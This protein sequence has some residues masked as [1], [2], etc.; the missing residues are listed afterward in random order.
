MEVGEATW[1]H[2]LHE[3]EDE[4][5]VLIVLCLEDVLQPDD[6][7]MARQPL[8]ATYTD[9]HLSPH[10]SPPT[11]HPKPRSKNCDQTQTSWCGKM[12][13]GGQLVSRRKNERTCKYM[14]SR[15]VRCASV[16]FWKASKIFF[17]ATTD[18]VFLSMALN[19]TA[20]APLPS[21]WVISYLRRTCCHRDVGVM[22]SPF[23]VY[24]TSCTLCRE[25][26]SNSTRGKQVSTAPVITEHMSMRLCDGCAKGKH[27][28][29]Q[30]SSFWDHI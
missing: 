26:D 25:P 11:H 15:K 7:V 19:T 16:A 1:A 12:V 8:R 13:A 4:I 6:I 14:I 3:V 20:Y 30:C 24:G 5:Y 17:S 29:H 2:R 18:F 9:Q 23:N 27:D 28:K 22:G 10:P 21:F